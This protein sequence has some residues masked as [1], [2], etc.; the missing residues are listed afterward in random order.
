MRAADRS[1]V[2]TTHA[3]DLLD[4]RKHPVR[5]LVVGNLDCVAMMATARGEPGSRGVNVRLKT[6]FNR[7]VAESATGDNLA[8]LARE[9]EKRGIPVFEVS[10]RDVH[11]ICSVCGDINSGPRKNQARFSCTTCGWSG[12]ADANACVVL[13]QRAYQQFVGPAAGGRN[14]PPGR[15]RLAFVDILGRPRR[16]TQPQTLR[17]DTPVRGR[18]KGA[19]TG[20][21]PGLRGVESCYPGSVV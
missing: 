15:T 3:Q 21:N 16:E 17:H 12:N 19:I 5:M 10:P 8:I 1:R 11:R 9:A 13:A 4:S 2:F 7:I 20:E 18:S 6:K 14:S